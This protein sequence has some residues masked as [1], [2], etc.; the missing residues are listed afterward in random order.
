METRTIK[1]M[2]KSAHSLKVR[3]ESMRK[4]QTEKSMETK[5]LSDSDR[6][7]GMASPTDGTKVGDPRN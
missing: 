4:T 3:T 5:T 7:P 6:S 1:E 2:N